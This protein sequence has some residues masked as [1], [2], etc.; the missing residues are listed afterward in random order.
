MQILSRTFVPL[1]IGSDGKGMIVDGDLA[2]M[3]QLTSGGALWWC[4]PS[5]SVM[6]LCT[7]NLDCSGS[8][9]WRIK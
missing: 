3:E 5:K 9:H 7:V 1:D 4:P 2:L 8:S 6:M